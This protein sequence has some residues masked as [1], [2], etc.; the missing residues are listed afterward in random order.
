MK[1]LFVC[2]AGYVSGR[3]IISLGQAEGVREHGAEVSFVVSTWNN[4]D[5]IKRLRK[6]D[7]QYTTLPLGFISK[8]LRFRPLL[9]T[10]YQMILMP[11][12][13]WSY[14]KLIKQLNP[15]VVIH[16]NFHHV[17]LLAGQIRPTRDYYVVHETI[18]EKSFY[19]SVV[20]RITKGIKSYIPV[21][22]F[23]GRNLTGLGIPERKIRV[24]KNGIVL[25][26][27]YKKREEVVQGLTLG[28]VGQVAECKGHEDVLSALAILKDKGFLPKL[29]IFG[30]STPDYRVK[31][32]SL[33]T[34]FGLA[35][36]I[37]WRGFER[38]QNKIYSCLDACLVLSRHGDPFPTSALE[39]A[40]YAMP[41][42]ASSQGGLPEIV[43]HGK[44]G[45]IC[46]PGDVNEIAGAIRK[47]YD[48][49]LCLDL[50]VAARERA[51]KYF[52]RSRMSSELHS[53]LAGTW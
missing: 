2:A 22:D 18:P 34:R 29:L 40:A 46:P 14:K 37:E 21:S 7:L 36:Q 12:L 53:F 1:V 31:L 17:I 15:D 26:S 5:F 35:P 11:R 27:D 45:F 41:V 30:A 28:I 39:A 48:R 16:T 23:V 8:T 13:I 38:D 9:I 24:I 52:Q 33:I 42:I 43:S 49:R 51:E 50:S 44:T 47:L 32:E 4:G 10:L 25:P 6:A 19:R 20:K 3:E